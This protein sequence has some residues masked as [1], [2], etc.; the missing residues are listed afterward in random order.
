MKKLSFTTWVAIC[1]F[2]LTGLSVVM[3]RG[4]SLRFILPLISVCILV[5]LYRLIRKALKEDGKVSNEDH[6]SGS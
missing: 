2:L 1:V 3:S 4:A 6:C 5:Y